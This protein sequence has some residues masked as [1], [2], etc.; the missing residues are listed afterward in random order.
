MKSMKNFADLGIN[1]PIVSEIT[2]TKKEIDQKIEAFNQQLKIEFEKIIKQGENKISKS[3]LDELTKEFFSTEYFTIKESVTDEKRWDELQTKWFKLN[4]KYFELTL[5]L[6]Q[7]GCSE[8]ELNY[9]M[10]SEFYKFFHEDPERRKQ[11]LEVPIQQK[12]DA[13][14][15]E[16][17]KVDAEQ[18]ALTIYSIVN[19]KKDISQHFENFYKK[20]LQII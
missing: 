7:T 5:E 4:K 19:N 15:E 6:T 13:V 1:I 14:E 20:V 12:I 16:V 2:G 3:K 10:E 17:A 18:Q 11:R 9:T 8:Y